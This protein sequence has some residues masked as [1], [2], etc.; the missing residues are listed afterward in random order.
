MVVFM[1]WLLLFSFSSANDDGGDIPS[2]RL[3]HQV[4]SRLTL[5]EGNQ[6]LCLL[7]DCR[8]SKSEAFVQVL[9]RSPV[10]V[11]V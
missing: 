7:G 6:F 9:L 2:K 8:D 1:F 4:V 11:C 5:V 10:G 3:V